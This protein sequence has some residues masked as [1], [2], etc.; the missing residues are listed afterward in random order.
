MVK[1]H[2]TIQN[3]QSLS[4]FNNKKIGVVKRYN[5]TSEFD[6]YK[7]FT[8][9]EFA[10]NE[11]LVTGLVEGFVDVIIGDFYTLSFV[12]RSYGY[13]NLVR[14]LPTS[15]KSIPRY[16]AFSKKSRDKSL[17]FEDALNKL[18]HSK[19]YKA[20]IEKYSIL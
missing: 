1:K 10:N 13:S 18:V 6:N 3:W 15:V 17:L 16:V 9:V 11:N 2:S 14:F 20:I 12:S 7:E 19:E 5:Y 8:K 4:D